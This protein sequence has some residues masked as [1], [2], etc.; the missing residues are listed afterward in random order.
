MFGEF[1]LDIYTINTCHCPTL[2]SIIAISDPA[3]L[4]LIPSPDELRQISAELYITNKIIEA[5]NLKPA[6]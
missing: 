6:S 5:F 1:I 2:I 4:L 3:Y